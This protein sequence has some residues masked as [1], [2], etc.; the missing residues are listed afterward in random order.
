MPAVLLL[1]GFP[2]S[3]LSRRHPSLVREAY[4]V[5]PDLPP[6]SCASSSGEHSRPG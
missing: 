4:V 1:H 6:R 3:A 5:A 2:T